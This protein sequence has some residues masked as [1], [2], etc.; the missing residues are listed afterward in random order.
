MV[1]FGESNKL[2]KIRGN[3]DKS[4]RSLFTEGLLQT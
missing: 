1:D 3:V 2:M 4:E